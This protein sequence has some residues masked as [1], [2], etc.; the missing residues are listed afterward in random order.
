MTND[1]LPFSPPS[2]LRL[3][4]RKA[5]NLLLLFVVIIVVSELY[6][7]PYLRWNYH[8]QGT[9]ENPVFLDAE[10]I[11][12]TGWRDVVAGEYSPGC[13]LVL[14]LKPERSVFQLAAEFTDKSFSKSRNE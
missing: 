14:W 2:V 8:Y 6:G 11:G 5:R 10:Y 9:Y 4:A 7:L 1:E 3:W 12:V 13:P